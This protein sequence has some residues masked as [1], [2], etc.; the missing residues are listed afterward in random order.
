MTDDEGPVTEALEDSTADLPPVSGK[1]SNEGQ[2]YRLKSQIG[3]GGMGEVLAA[4]DERFGREVAVKRLVRR[5]T[6]MESSDTSQRRF[7]REAVIQGRL[8][9]PAIVPIYDLGV[10]D[11][12]RPYFSM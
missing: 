10:D 8:D 2:R 3:K 1:S 9:H 12:G 7:V 11:E 4:T 5:M 6:S